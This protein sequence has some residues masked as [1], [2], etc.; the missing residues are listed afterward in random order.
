MSGNADSTGRLSKSD[1]TNEMTALCFS[2]KGEFVTRS[3]AGETIIVPVRGRIGDLDSIY[4]LSEVASLI[5][6]RIDGKTPVWQISAE[7]CTEFDVEPEI[8]EKDT[9][10][11]IAELQGASLI[12]PVPESKTEEA[13]CQQT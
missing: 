11:F 1:R 10:Q 9:L 7:I 5:W 13:E 2:K 3:I 8:A 12:E 6:S 4:N